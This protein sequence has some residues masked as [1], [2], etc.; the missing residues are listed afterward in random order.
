MNT[1]R[2]KVI[3]TYTV[4]FLVAMALIAAIIFGMILAVRG[5]NA[6]PDYAYA[7]KVSSSVEDA[8]NYYENPTLAIACATLDLPYDTYAEDINENPISKT[9]V[10]TSIDKS[11]NVTIYYNQSWFAE[12]DKMK[13]ILKERKEIK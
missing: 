13:L 3:E 2:D 8:H 7:M 6:T 4:L 9:I 12:I 11:G 10:S 5:S 1:E